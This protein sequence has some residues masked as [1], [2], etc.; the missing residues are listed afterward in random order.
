M[1]TSQALLSLFGEQHVGDHVSSSYQADMQ[2]L[3]CIQEGRKTVVTAFEGKDTAISGQKPN[4][5]DVRVGP[6]GVAGGNG[7]TV[8]MGRSGLHGRQAGI[9]VDGNVQPSLPMAKM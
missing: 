1:P 5:P 3:G 6:N 9:D 8:V 4:G 2:R 7:I